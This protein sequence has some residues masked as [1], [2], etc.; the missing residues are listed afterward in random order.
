MDV[1]VVGVAT[2]QLSLPV[3]TFP[4]EFNPRRYL[5][6]GISV[7]VGGAGYSV[8]RHSARLGHEAFLV[9]PIGE[10]MAA[11]TIDLT[12]ERDR[13][14]TALCARVLR[15]TP[16]SVLLQAEGGQRAAFSDLA[17]VAEA[18]VDSPEVLAALRTA[19]VAVLGNVDFSLPLIPVAKGAGVPVVVDLQDVRDVRAPELD[20]FTAADVLTMANT[21]HVG[22]EATALRALRERGARGFLV[23]TMGT[24]GLMILPPDEDEPCGVTVVPAREV[25]TTEGAGDVFLACLV[26]ALYAQRLPWAEASTRA[27]RQT[28]IHLESGNPGPHW[29]PQKEELEDGRTDPEELARFLGRPWITGGW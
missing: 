21:Y 14:N 10:D 13:V 24:A 4:I 29:Y 6:G 9:A 28:A 5:P 23:V 25:T 7:E 16:R 19:D 11:S 26:D 15:R 18:R 2:Q 27:G 3:E 1:I 20:A 12:A 22:D 8:A 17:G